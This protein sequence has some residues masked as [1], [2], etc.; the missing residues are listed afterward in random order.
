MSTL[1]PPGPLVPKKK[2]TTPP[3]DN[4][5]HL[6][7]PPEYGVLLDTMKAR[8]GRTRT[9][10]TQVALEKLAREM[11]IPFKPNWPELL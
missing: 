5:V 2:Q 7:L 11:G 8:T 10:S 6:R 9:I 4:D 1:A 3:T